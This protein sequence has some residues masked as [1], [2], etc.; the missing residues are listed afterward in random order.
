MEPVLH[1]LVNR[2][3]FHDETNRERI[4]QL[5]IL[6]QELQVKDENGQEALLFVEC[7][8]REIAFML[9]KHEGWKG[10]TLP[11]LEHTIDDVKSGFDRHSPAAEG[12]K[13]ALRNFF[14]G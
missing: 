14:E 1:I 4:I 2:F 6:L 10:L 9:Q 13:V 11:E 3:P 5:T 8:T 12:L 7:T